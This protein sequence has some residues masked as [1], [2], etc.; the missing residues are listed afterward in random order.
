VARPR[1]ADAQFDLR[2]AFDRGRALL[3]ENGARPTAVGVSFGGPVDYAAGRVRLSHHVEGWQGVPLRDQ[4][5]AAF[6]APACI[7][8]DANC[9]ALAEW[10]LGAGA[11]SV[12]AQATGSL[13]YVTVSTG[14][15]GGWVVNGEVY[16]G[17]NSMAGEIGHTNA[18]PD[19]PPCI[20][21]RRGCVE[22]MACGP[23]IAAAA[24][25]RVEADPASGAALREMAGGDPGAITAALVAQAASQGDTLSAG[26]LLAAARYLG[27]GLGNAASLMAPGLIVLGGGVT[28][29]GA[30]WWAEVRRA[31]SANTLPEV[32]VNLAPTQLGDDAPLWGAA[33][34]AA[35]VGQP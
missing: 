12:E 28:K 15:G 3:A 7:D 35:G 11:A 17:A 4:A 10:R 32:V 1:G 16:R 30:A 24:R 21:G 34:L 6:D 31:A 2:A 26:V 25:A 9:G 18:D 14:I 23:A 29:S 22:V 20:C 8:N 13:L 19:G 33:L 5:A 27:N